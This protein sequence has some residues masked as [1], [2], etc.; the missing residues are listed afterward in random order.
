MSAEHFKIFLF[1]V[2]ELTDGMCLTGI[3]NFD[4]QQ[5]AVLSSKSTHEV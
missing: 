2:F 3:N 4:V 5:L 1:K